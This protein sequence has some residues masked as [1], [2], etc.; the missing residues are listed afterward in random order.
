MV[1]SRLDIGEIERAIRASA[2]DIDAPWRDLGE[3]AM[4]DDLVRRL[5]DGYRFVDS[6]LAERRDV[7]AYGQSAAL[8]ELNHRV[9]C[10]VTPERRAQY[11]GHIVETERHF[12]DNPNGGVAAFAD[13]YRRNRNRVPNLLA[14]GI[15]TQVVSWPQLFIEGNSRTAALLASFCLARAG[16]PPLVVTKESAVEYHGLVDRCMV[17]HSTGVTRAFAMSMQTYR[18]AG[19][20]ARIAQPRFLAAEPTDVPA[21]PRAV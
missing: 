15:F 7:F 20:I 8:I 13:W 18:L 9:L 1:W 21:E 3:E 5:M 16:F 12:Y 10:G 14:G 2:D 4:S 17:V 6:W 19:F 11:S